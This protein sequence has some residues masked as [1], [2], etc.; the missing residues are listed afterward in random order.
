MKTLFRNAKVW[1]GEL[2]FTDSVGFDSSTGKIIFCGNENEISAKDFNEVIDLKGKL[3]LPSFTDGHVHLVAGSLVNSQINFRFASTK[4]DFKNEI[5]RYRQQI[6]YGDIIVGGYFSEAYF[7]ENFKLERYFLDSICGDI[8]MVILRNDL[9]SCVLNSKAIEYLGIENTLKKFHPDEAPRD[10]IGNLTG[11]FMENAFTFIRKIIP[12]KSIIE[13]S[14]I[15]KKEIE[16]LHSFGITAVSDISFIEDLDIYEYLL[17]KKDLNMKIDSRIPIEEFGKI[18]N[19][20]NRFANYQDWI[21]FK[22]LKAFY[23]GSLS[24][25]TAY[26]SSNYKGTDYKGLKTDLV[27][28]GTFYKSVFEIDKAG[29][30]L[31]VHAIGDLAVS[32]LLDILK[33]IEI[34][35]GIRD[36]RFRIE[37][38]QHIN[39]KDYPKFKKLNAIVSVQPSHLNFDANLAKEKIEDLNSTHRF[40]PLI[41]DGVTVCFGTDFPVVSENPFETIYYAM[42]R[43][44]EGFPEG[45]NKE[46]NLDLETCLKAYTINNAYASYDE[47]KRG[48]ITEGKDADIIVVQDDLYL[49]EPDKIKNSKVEMTYLNGKRVF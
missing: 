6:K 45:F 27:N 38:A 20:K 42:T 5:S 12:Q 25:R 2:N 46:Y 14:E 47:K 18:D 43:K 31:S 19:I 16:R 28:N 1:T 17:N 7:K 24:S 23:D 44:V 13:K 32:E 8:P 33:E 41:D 15:L 26:F 22:S 11:E 49:I 48:S 21:K 34:K 10:Y 35:N 9:H 29:Y 40:K 37:H 30:Q 3:V 39:K 4:E 36:R